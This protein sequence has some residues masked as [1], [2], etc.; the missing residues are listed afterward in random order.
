MGTEIMAEQNRQMHSFCYWFIIY[1]FHLVGT[2][3]TKASSKY[4]TI[5]YKTFKSNFKQCQTRISLETPFFPLL[6]YKSLDCYYIIQPNVRIRCNTCLKW[7]K[8]SCTYNVYLNDYIDFDTTN[9]Q[10]VKNQTTKFYMVYVILFF[11]K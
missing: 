4:E 5:Q 1:K 8:Y 11:V 2:N 9:F 3:M 6:Y 10:N 7:C